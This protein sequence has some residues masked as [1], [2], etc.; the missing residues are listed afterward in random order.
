MSVPTPRVVTD[1]DYR[2]KLPDIWRVLCGRVDGSGRMVT[3]AD[4]LAREAAC[5]KRSVDRAFEVLRQA[6]VVSTVRTEVG[7]VVTLTGWQPSSGD[8][9][10][11][12]GRVGVGWSWRDGAACRDRPDVDFLSGD[13]AVMRTAQQV[14][15]GCPVAGECLEWALS[16]R[17]VWGVWGGVTPTQRRKLRRRPG[18]GERTERQAEAAA[19]LQQAETA[20]ER[21]SFTAEE[22][23]TLTEEARKLRAAGWSERDIAGEL[24]VSRTTVHRIVAQPSAERAARR[25]AEEQAARQA[26]RSREEQ[27]TARIEAAKRLRA[28][29]HTERGIAMMLQASKSTVHR[30]VSQLGETG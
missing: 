21:R 30:D 8:V 2:S 7:S 29:G 4:D 23:A 15:A 5:S 6:G 10:S 13:T 22:M 26:G 11:V 27:R 18:R 1:A 25:A 20:R 28:A 24:G 16:R 19:H 14:C 12:R 17:E 3:T 9:L